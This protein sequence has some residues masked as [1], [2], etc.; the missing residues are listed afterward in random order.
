M[1]LGV[2]SNLLVRDAGIAGVVIR[3]GKGFTEVKFSGNL[4]EAGSAALCYN[5][6]QLVLS[7]SLSGLEFWSGIPGTVGGALSMNAG[8]YG[9]ETADRLEAA[10]AIDESGSIHQ[11]KP[12]DIGYVYRGH[13]MPE[14]MFFT[15]GW[16]RLTEKSQAEIST[17]MNAIRDAR[18]DSQPIRSRTGGSTFK[19]PAGKKAWQLIDSAGC[20]GLKNGDAQISN[21]HCNFLI[22]NGN[23]TATE[24]E[25]LI[26]EVQRRVYEHSSVMLE[27]EIKCVGR[28]KNE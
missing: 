23:A 13:T 10:E 16:W 24:I 19:N 28:Q 18:V 26:N 11:L 14:K 22:N 17:A 5:V 6:S 8:A 15:R 3:L 21:Q 2:G 1:I 25:A 4:I 9:S 20:R 27:V 12:S 7:K